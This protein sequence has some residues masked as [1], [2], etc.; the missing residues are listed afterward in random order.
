MQSCGS[1][2]NEVQESG[3]GNLVEK[4]A[5]ILGLNAEATKMLLNAVENASKY[6]KA[7]EVLGKFTKILAT[8]SGVPCAL[9]SVGKAFNNPTSA[10]IVAAISNSALLLAGPELSILSG[11]LDLTGVS[12]KFYNFVGKKIDNSIENTFDVYYNLN[13]NINRILSPANLLNP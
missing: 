3:Q 13:Q 12:D 8:L 10:N 6:G 1:V 2:G 5:T 9:I 4:I 7:V 11:I